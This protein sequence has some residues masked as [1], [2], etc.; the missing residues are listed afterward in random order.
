MFHFEVIFT[1]VLVLKGAETLAQQ[2][3]RT[4][5]GASEFVA[6]D[7]IVGFSEALTSC[8]RRGGQL[9]VPFNNAEH[10]ATVQLALDLGGEEP[11][12]LGKEAARI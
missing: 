5:V 8:V 2:E 4:C 10:N 3:Q 12:W 9:A 11:F 1:W 6:V 7:E